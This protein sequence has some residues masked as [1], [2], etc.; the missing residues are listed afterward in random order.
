MGKYLY[1]RN[2]TT[3]NDS[4][5]SVCIPV[6]NIRGVTIPTRSSMRIHYV[7][8]YN[9]SGDGGSDVVCDTAS[10][11]IRIGSSF[12]AI[13]A[14]SVAMS[15][16]SNDGRIVVMDDITGESLSPGNILS[17]S[18]TQLVTNAMFS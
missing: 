5:D 8:A 18:N 15:S 9:A 6:E 7:S 16:G 13:K 3:T 2:N 4:R 14:L 17:I 12:E 11:A 1:F 10:F